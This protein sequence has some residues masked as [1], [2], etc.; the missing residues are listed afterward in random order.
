MGLPKFALIDGAHIAIISSRESRLSVYCFAPHS[1]HEPSP[2]P[3]C[4]LCLPGAEH[5]NLKTPPR[6]FFFIQDLYISPLLSSRP[7]TKPQP[8][9]LNAE[10]AVVLV[11]F[12][13][14]TGLDSGHYILLVPIFTLQAAVRRA[15]LQHLRKELAFAWSEWGRD[16]LLLRKEPKSCD[17]L[18]YPVAYGRP[19]GSRLPI[20]FYPE[21][22]NSE[23][24]QVLIIEA[25]HRAVRYAHKKTSLGES[26]LLHESKLKDTRSRLDC[27]VRST[28]HGHEMPLP[29]TVYPGPVV[30]CPEGFEPEEIVLDE[31]A[32]SILV[33]R[34]YNDGFGLSV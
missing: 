17:S 5:G 12:G 29:F 9:E 16:A 10:S 7:P 31:G 13:T 34:T 8:F 28:L 24:G 32:I 2:Y 25:D 23:K 11:D 30:S 33:S 6:N 3:V 18:I 22:I 19:C 27:H 15:H 14:T 26:A 21:G 4:E 20:L 1:D